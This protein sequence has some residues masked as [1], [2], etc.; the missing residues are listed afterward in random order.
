MSAMPRN[1]P[2]RVPGREL[3]DVLQARLLVE[4]GE[5]E[6]VGVLARG[7]REL[8]H[9]RLVGERV[10]RVRHRAPVADAHARVV[11]HHVGQLVR[12]VVGH[13]GR[14]GHER[15]DAVL[16]HRGEEP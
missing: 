16:H 5:A 11:D 10:E 12:Y 4:Q 7:E 13:R 8:V 2:A 9:E 6:L 14:L 3:E 1:R 15:V